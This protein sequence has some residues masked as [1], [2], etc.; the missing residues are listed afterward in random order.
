MST[1]NVIHMP[2]QSRFLL[3]MVLLLAM[4][5]PAFASET[6]N[7]QNIGNNTA[8]LLHIDGAIDP[9]TS[10]YVQRG[11]SKAAAQQAHLV[12]LQINT[13]GGLDTAMREII[14]AIISSPV[15]VVGYVAPGGA[16]AA[17]AG[18]Y[19]LYASHIA[20]MTPATTLGAATPIKI[21]GWPSLSDDN[22]NHDEQDALTKKIVNDAAAYIR[23]LADMRGRN[24]DWAEQAVRT[25]ASLTADEALEQQVINLTA[26]S[27]TGLLHK[28]NNYVVDMEGQ[29]ITLST[30]ATTLE[31]I[32]PD[33]RT[34]LLAVIANPNMAYILM[35]A[36]IY[37]LVLEFLHPG[38]LIA[39]VVGAISLL[40]ALFAFQLLPIDYTGLILILLG[41]ALMLAEAFAPGFGVLGVGGT[42][43]F[44][45]GSVML[46]DTDIPG[47]GISIPLIA[48][49][50]L[51]SVGLCVFVI[52]M[53]LKS[54]RQPV[55]T[56]QEELIRSTGEVI[57]DFNDKGW[58][59]VQ[60]EL[61]QARTQTP[62]AAGQQV[63]IAAIHGLLLEVE[64]IPPAEETHP[65]S[66]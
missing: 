57:D 15:P 5:L 19:I 31:S 44:A 8:V 10:D 21:G 55:E 2:Q 52:G 20:A 12:I 48:T 6:D 9:A 28:L 65:A 63:R 22:K 26:N 16:R 4:T 32:A 58:V 34:R 45:I 60:G 24:A 50:T 30:T 38:T 39:G 3:T 64:P 59:R 7:Q 17:S 41:I 1:S 18:T 46:I 56:G 11:L 29:Q 40:L 14:Q 53:L 35:L 54:R 13:P 49:F 33:W 37:G 62:L 51:L 66:A 43:A 47:Y 61:W 23:S 42:I 36:G 25:G 27:I